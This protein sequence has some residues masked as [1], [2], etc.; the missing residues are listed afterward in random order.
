M[1]I[2]KK[3]VTLK[4]SMGNYSLSY[5]ITNNLFCPKCGNKK[6]WK[7]IS[8]EIQPPRFTSFICSKC[9]F[10]FE[11]EL[12]PKNQDRFE[13]VVKQLKDEEEKPVVTQAMDRMDV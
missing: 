8:T 9:S 10:P 11:I 2:L 5:E 3:K 4:D 6:N 12:N 1:S 7:E 13:D